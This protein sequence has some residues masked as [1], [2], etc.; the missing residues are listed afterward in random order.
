M[1]HDFV[2]GSSDSVTQQDAENK[3]SYFSLIVLV[4]AMFYVE[5]GASGMVCAQSWS[6]S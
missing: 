5:E 4:C 1:P 3:G 2:L 6:T